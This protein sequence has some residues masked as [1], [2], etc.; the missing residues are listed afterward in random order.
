[1]L[2]KKT[3][4]GDIS[5]LRRRLETRVGDDCRSP[6]GV[7]I[8]YGSDFSRVLIMIIEAKRVVCCILHVSSVDGGASDW[9]T[10]LSD[11]IKM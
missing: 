5:R 6:S 9:T 4:P 1:M 11:A 2:A 7:P 8:N 10:I 3:L